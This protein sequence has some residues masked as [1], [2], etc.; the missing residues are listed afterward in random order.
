MRKINYN[1][2]FLFFIIVV[3]IFPI[4]F[5]LAD[6]CDDVTFE[7][8]KVLASN[9][10]VHYEYLD[11]DD[12]TLG[13]GTAIPYGYTYAI[14]ISGLN[15]EIFAISE[16]EQL[17]EFNSS[18]AIDGNV[19]YYVY[20]NKKDLYVKLYPSVC[21]AKALKTFQLS[22]PVINDYYF[23]Q[24]CSEINE[25]GIDLEVCHKLIPNDLKISDQY[26]FEV[27]NKYLPNDESEN[28][29]F[30]QSLML[31]HNP[32]FVIGGSIVIILIIVGIVLYIRKRSVLE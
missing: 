30:S 1:I 17:Q 6:S 11:P 28:D 21:D 3:Y 2:L 31:L 9:V 10:Q 13:W 14:T 18:Q 12:E 23:R 27:V 4:D 8:L 24:E 32:Y 22:L 29:F 26:F 7:R 19:V 5:V 20:N 15:D 16:G 25:K